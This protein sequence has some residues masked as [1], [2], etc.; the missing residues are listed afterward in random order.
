LATERPEFS[1]AQH[2]FV[3]AT[4]YDVLA[5]RL[6]RRYGDALSGRSE[7]FGEV[8]W[9]VSVQHGPKTP[10]V[11]RALEP[12][13]DA[14][15]LATTDDGQLIE[16]I[17]AEREREDRRG[18]LVYF[19]RSSEA[20]QDGLRDRFETERSD[21]LAALESELNP[22][23]APPPVIPLPEPL[24]PPFVDPSPTPIYEPT[25]TPTVHLDAPQVAGNWYGFAY[26]DADA[27]RTRPAFIVSLSIQPVTSDGFGGYIGEYRDGFFAVVTVGREEG[28]P[29]W[30][31]FPAPQALEHT[32]DENGVSM[33]VYSLGGPGPAHS[34]LT[35]TV[36]VSGN[37][38][39]GRW[40]ITPADGQPY[41][42]ATMNGSVVPP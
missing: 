33:F 38:L 35:V 28:V 12:F 22:P 25:P 42:P 6:D 23:P 5:G 2:D 36:S 1:A 13:A 32:L 11:Q 4:R 21:A 19:R 39:T 7:A 9:S 31:E 30:P 27:V 20:V 10:L 17:Y 8:I 26:Q 37:Y 34:K 16:A 3:E 14:G 18:N 24:P 40:H 41:D 15:T 29:G